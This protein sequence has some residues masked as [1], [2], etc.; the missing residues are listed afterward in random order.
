MIRL[1]LM[2]LA[3]MCCLSVLSSQTTPIKWSFSVENGEQST[4][5]IICQ[6]ELEPGWYIYS[7]F[8]GEDGPI[9]TTITL[10]DSGE[11]AIQGGP[12]EEGEKKE[13][14][15][16]LFD[17]HI[18]KFSKSATFAQPINLQADNATIRGSVEYMTC[19]DHK[20]LPPTTAEFTLRVSN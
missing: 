7:Q 20:C 12:T 18:V 15:D 8:L 9:P 11:Y 17:M 10:D 4:H 6:A 5:K 19:D 2:L 14:H 3:S 1:G 13:G 16:P